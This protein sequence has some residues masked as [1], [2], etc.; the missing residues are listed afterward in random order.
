M[1]NAAIFDHTIPDVRGTCIKV[2]AFFKER[3]SIKEKIAK[4]NF[5]LKDI[6]SSFLVGF[7]D[8]ASSLSTV[9]VAVWSFFGGLE[10]TFLSDGS[11]ANDPTRELCLWL[12]ILETDVY[13]N[14]KVIVEW[15]NQ[16]HALEAAPHW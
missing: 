7:F 15:A 9:E 5:C 8:G 14:S 11:V 2:V 12:E 3:G 16:R 10:T 6:W 1:R 13:G 4:R